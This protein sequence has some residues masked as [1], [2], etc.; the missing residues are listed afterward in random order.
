MVTN[1]PIAQTPQ[2]L[3]QRPWLVSLLLGL[4]TLSL[5]LHLWTLTTLAGI[6]LL[7]HDQVI[8][9]ADQVGDARD[10]VITVSVPI[11]QSVPISATIPVYQQLAVPIKTTVEI[12]QPIEIPISTPFGSTSVQLPIKLR[13]PIDT[14]V[15]IT[16]NE[17]VVIN[18]SVNLD[19]TIP[20]SIPLRDTHIAVYLENLQRNLIALSKRLSNPTNPSIWWVS[21]G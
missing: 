21:G 16:I 13:V 19:T 20:I 17:Q 7:V 12:D 8:A 3:Q 1:R 15:P 14:S 4:L 9:L 2:P 11:K 5:G 10:D 18:T 6:R